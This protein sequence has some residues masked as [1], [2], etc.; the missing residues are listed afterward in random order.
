MGGAEGSGVLAFGLS[1]CTAQRRICSGGNA[2]YAV[3]ET[4]GRQYK[5]SP[6]EVIEV[7]RLPVEVG[8]T[9]NLTNVLLIGGGEE[10][11][12]IGQ[13]TIPGA[14]VRAHVSGN[15][16]SRKIIVFKYKPKVRYRRMN[17]HR[18]DLTRLVIKEILPSGAGLEEA[19]ASAEPT[20][21]A[22]VL[23]DVGAVPEAPVEE[24]GAASDAEAAEA[25]PAVTAEESEVA[26]A[27]EPVE[28]A[29]EDRETV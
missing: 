27:A 22:D 23:V 26:T 19:A 2:V 21:A 15:P 12:V 18:Q 17:T 13:P 11:T 29:P 6:G 8:Q 16:R 4:G 9:I 3:I 7:N 10:G 24:T 1:L 25:A 5:V 28:A 20:E 14:A